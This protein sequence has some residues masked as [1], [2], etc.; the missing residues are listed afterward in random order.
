MFSTAHIP[1]AEVGKEWQLSHF[2]IT[3]CDAR[4]C[5]HQTKMAR[6]APGFYA[7]RRLAS[8]LQRS[9]RWTND[10]VDAGHALPRRHRR[11]WRSRQLQRPAG[12]EWPITFWCNRIAQCTRRLALLP[13]T[14][15]IVASVESSGPGHISH[16]DSNVRQPYAR[17]N[18]TSCSAVLIDP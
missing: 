7:C 11:T 5:D 16:D 14:L 1:L 12:F 2:K 17:R 3:E 10:T 13:L 18:G 6:S 9:C 8:W 4:H 15:D